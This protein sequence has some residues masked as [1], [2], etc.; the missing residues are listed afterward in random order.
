MPVDRHITRLSEEHL[1][2]IPADFFIHGVCL[3]EDHG[4]TAIVIDFDVVGTGE[5]PRDAISDAMRCTDEYLE[6]CLD[7][8]FE[9]ED[10]FREAPKEYE[11]RYQEAFEASLNRMIE[12]SSKQEAF[13]QPILA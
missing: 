12:H 7:E 4:W 9:F 5:T 8:G 2:K 1:K 3:R 11:R 13:R 6:M 10:T